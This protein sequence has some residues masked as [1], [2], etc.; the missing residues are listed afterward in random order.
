[1][2]F[3]LGLTDAASECFCC[4]KKSFCTTLHTFGF[5]ASRFLFEFKIDAALTVSQ[6]D[7]NPVL[8][9]FF[10]KLVKGMN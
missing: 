8:D 10:L 5:M 7:W 2:L 4:F 3:D 6:D 1:M 9:G